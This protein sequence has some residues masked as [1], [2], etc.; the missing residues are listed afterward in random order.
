MHFTS[1]NRQLDAVEGHYFGA[2]LAQ[3]LSGAERATQLAHPDGGALGRH[4]ASG[5]WQRGWD[6]VIAR[7]PVETDAVERVVL[8]VKAALLALEQGLDDEAVA[9]H[10]RVVVEGHGMDQYWARIYMALL[11]VAVSARLR[12][13]GE[14]LRSLTRY[15]AAVTAQEHQRRAYRT[16]QAGLWALDAGVSPAQVRGFLA[17]TGVKPEHPGARASFAH[18]EC[19]LLET[20]GSVA[21]AVAAGRDAVDCMDLPASWRADAHTRL[22]RCLVADRPGVGGSP[23][24]SGSRW[25]CWRSGPAGGDV[26]PSRC[27]RVSTL[28]TG[29]SPSGSGRSARW[30]SRAYRT[31]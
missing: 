24:Q 20:E 18:L 19:A 11:D 7:L 28:P 12:G 10:E 23:A 5:Q 27:V 6:I 17:A 31:G 14:A 25:R 4:P 3:A 13:Q 29:N 30:S 2:P 9:L 26:P 16:A 1:R 21:A 15:R 8:S 22:G